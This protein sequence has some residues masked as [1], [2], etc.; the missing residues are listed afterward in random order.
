MEFNNFRKLVRKLL[1]ES[2]NM[3]LDNDMMDEER[4]TNPESKEYVERRE[5]FHWLA[6]LWRRFGRFRINVRG[7]FI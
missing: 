6:L 4:I 1:R 5:N 2:I 7:I 3:T